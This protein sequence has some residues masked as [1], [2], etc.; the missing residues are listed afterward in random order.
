LFT[1]IYDLKAQQKYLPWINLNQAK[2][3][4]I[5]RKSPA[6]ISKDW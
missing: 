1:F 3:A 4:M 2:I 5:L 6:T